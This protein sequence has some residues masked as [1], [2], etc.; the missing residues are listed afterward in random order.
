M[1][2]RYFLFITITSITLSIFP[3]F[4]AKDLSSKLLHD[5]YPILLITIYNVS[6]LVG[7]SLTVIY[8]VNDIKK[9]I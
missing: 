3:G 4:I 5:W 2:L 6:D 7:K 1:D 8:I 9:V